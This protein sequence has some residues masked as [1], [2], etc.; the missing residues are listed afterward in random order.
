VDGFLPAGAVAELGLAGVGASLREVHLPGTQLD[1][2]LLRERST[3]YHLRLV[4]EELYLL[5]I[6][7]GLRKRTLLR[8]HTAALPIDD[9]ATARAALLFA[10]PRPAARGA[11]RAIR[12]LHPDEPDADR[13]RGHRKTALRCSLPPPRTP[14][15]GLRRCWR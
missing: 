8:R 11:I 9:E 14:R 6:G 15:S 2:N 13:R 4:A 5:Q 1:P 7:L 3:P 10:S 12:A